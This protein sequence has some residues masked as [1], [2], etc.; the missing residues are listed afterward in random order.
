M[1]PVVLLVIFCATM[2][3]ITIGRF[4]RGDERDPVDAGTALVLA[5]ITVLTGVW[6][7]F[8]E[9][10]ELTGGLV[11]LA[12]SGSVLIGAGIVVIGTHWNESVNDDSL[13][14]VETVGDEEVESTQQ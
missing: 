11:V 10:T 1:T 3:V 4:A 13:E 5:G 9:L 2:T 14:T 12:G 6:V 7:G 8:E